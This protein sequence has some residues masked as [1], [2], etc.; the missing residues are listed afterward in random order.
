MDPWLEH[1]SRWRDVH[2]SLVTY[3]RDDIQAALPPRYVARMEDRVYLEAQEHGIAPDVRVV[4]RP[5]S[6]TARRRARAAS[7]ADVAVIVKA[8]V[9]VEERYVEILDLEAGSAI[10]T[11][12]E[13]LSPTN[14]RPGAEGAR[15]YRAKQTEVL[16]S[17][18]NLVEIDL[19]RG[20]AH[21]V[22]VPEGQLA[23]VRPFDYLVVVRA[24]LPRI[25]IPLREPDEDVVADLQSL[26][27]RAWE[28]GAYSKTIDYATP[29]EPPL[30]PADASSARRLARKARR[31]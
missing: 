27:E 3:L 31:R 20:G 30:P 13:V 23:R 12:I 17:D 18:A 22:A 10:V 8:E 6:P 24:R 11:V 1:P 25:A 2:S 28:R 21:T 9:E 14:K 5:G 26:V 15:A 4:E 7:R 16:G 29:A 19:L